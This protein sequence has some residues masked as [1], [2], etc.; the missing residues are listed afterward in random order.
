MRRTAGRVRTA[1]K[2]GALYG[3]YRSSFL[4]FPAAFLLRFMQQLMGYFNFPAGVTRR[5]SRNSP[6]R[7]KNGSGKVYMDNCRKNF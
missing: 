6:G 1:G 4:G 5:F 7:W 2:R 3:R